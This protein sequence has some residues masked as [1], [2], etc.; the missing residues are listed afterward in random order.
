[1]SLA[2]ADR[3]IALAD[4]AGIAVERETNHHPTPASRRGQLIHFLEVFGL[5]ASPMQ[6]AHFLGVTEAEIRKFLSRRGVR[7]AEYET[8]KERFD[9]IITVG[10]M[11]EDF[12]PNPYSI[13]DR[14]AM[15]ATQNPLFADEKG[16]SR[17]ALD[18]MVSGETPRVVAVLQNTF[19]F[20]NREHPD[21]M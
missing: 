21:S 16:Q 7:E 8:I 2:E 12:Y 10:R 5:E 18:L 4:F 13:P 19:E 14:R 15:I 9:G 11:A 20:L 3:G 1:M 17:S 6:L